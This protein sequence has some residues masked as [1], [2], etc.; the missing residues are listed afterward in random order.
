VLH[1]A[2]DGKPILTASARSYRKR[3]YGDPMV[4]ALH[5]AFSTAG[6]PTTTPLWINRPRTIFVMGIATITAV[7]L[8]FCMFAWLIFRG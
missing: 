7:L 2:P 8:C 3:V 1:F 6:L 5:R 4:D